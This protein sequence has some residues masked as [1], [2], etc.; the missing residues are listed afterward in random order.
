VEINKFDIEGPIEII[1]D[2]FHD[3]RGYFF[4]SY[5][6][7]KYK[8]ILGDVQFLQDNQSFSKSGVIRG[9]HLQKPPFAQAKLIKVTKGRVIDLAM[10]IRKDSKT[11]GKFIKVELNDKK[12]NLLFIPEGF[13]HA[14]ITLE[15]SIFQYKCSNYYSK[16]SE[17]SINPF[18]IGLD[19]GLM[20]PIISEKDK[21]GIL[22]SDFISPF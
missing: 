22:F 9:F 1:P 6:D 10:D 4:E 17:M 15:D 3:E 18:S 21:S 11:Y 14:F 7:S 2:V 19:L 8:E 5:N 13:A 12:Q 16:E 20:E